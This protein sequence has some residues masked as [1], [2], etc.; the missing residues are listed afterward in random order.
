LAILKTVAIFA[1]VMDASYSL[2]MSTVNSILV[3][4]PP[5]LERKF[6]FHPNFLFAVE[7]LTLMRVARERR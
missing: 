2:N 1:L 7:L 6:P 3:A 4:S 5:Q